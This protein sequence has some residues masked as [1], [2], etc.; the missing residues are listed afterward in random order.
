MGLIVLSGALSACGKNTQ[1]HPQWSDQNA[2]NGLQTSS[3]SISQAQ[4]CS[5]EP[6]INSTT[7]SFAPQTDRQYRACKGN[8]IGGS[9]NQ[10]ALFPA[11]GQTKN[12]CVFPVQI[13]NNSPAV[14]VSNPYASVNNRYV[15][16]CVTAPGTG[17]LLNF[18]NLS[19]Q[20]AFIV[21]AAD[22]NTFVNCLAGGN[23]GYCAANMGIEFSAG[24]VA[25]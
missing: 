1:S 15:V 2:T 22:A 9:A 10:L 12:V 4:K 7:T 16:Q 25:Q 21:N 14:L 17:S 23:L 8:V 18:A 11:D 3:T 13:I 19:Y 24:T 6:N 5:Y 20:A